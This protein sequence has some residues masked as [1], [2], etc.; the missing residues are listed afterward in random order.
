M[1]QV[2]ELSERSQVDELVYESYE[3]PVAVFKHSIA[4]PI[5]ARGQ[6]E[7][8]ALEDDGDPPLYA[9]VVQYARDVSNYIAEKVGVRHET[10]QVLILSGG[11]VVYSASHFDI[12][13]DAL[14]EAAQQAADSSDS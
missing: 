2:Q 5:S 13:S 4:C 9:V 1:A 14:R 7:F 10:P 6:R 11:E 12:K 3:H 8:V